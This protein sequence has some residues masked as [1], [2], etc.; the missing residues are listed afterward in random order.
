M[1]IKKRTGIA[2][3]VALFFTLVL[4]LMIF[5]MMA[6]HKNVAQQNRVSLQHQ[7]AVFAARAALQHLLLK[8]K[9]FP[10][11]LYD[12]V[13]FSQGKNPLFDFTEYPSQVNNEVAFKADA[14][15]PNLFVR[16]KPAPELDLKL[17]PKFF[18][19][20][21]D[22]RP[23]VFVRIGNYFTPEFRFLD[24]GIVV[25][26][27]TSQKYTLPDIKKLPGY[28]TIKPDKFLKYFIRDCTNTKARSISTG[29]FDGPI[30]Q[31]GLV[32]DKDLNLQSI[33][34]YDITA[35]NQLRSYPYTMTYSVE[36]IKV[37]SLKDLRRYNE[38][39]IEIKV[40]GTITD[41]QGKKYTEV[42]TR[43]QKI[44]RR[45]AL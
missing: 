28:S 17:Q 35:N 42:M 6:T 36:E 4:M 39:A 33:K 37:G 44:T 12:A 16:I 3:V 24:S 7:Q 29:N 25:N 40:V 23:D 22:D 9:L 34:D 14:Q 5:S 43:T 19:I 10:T 41:F 30:V 45:G 27:P 15:V 18:Y 32:M 31:S 11:E 1:N 8:A 38:E 13:E 2:I 20:Q 26:S 21:F